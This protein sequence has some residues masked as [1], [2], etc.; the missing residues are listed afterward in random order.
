MPIRL[1]AMIV[2]K[3]SSGCGP[4]DAQSALGGRGAPDGLLDLSLL[5]YVTG[6]E[7]RLELFAQ[8]LALIGV[9][10]GD[11]DGRA[12]RRKRAHG[13]LAE[14]RS[15]A[16]G[17]RCR[18]LDVHRAGSLQVAAPRQREREQALRIGH[19]MRDLQARRG[20]VALEPLRREL[21]GDLRA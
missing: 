16:H 20:E 8:R 13:R 1:I 21:G 9:D 6:D 4:R 2:S 12:A 14:A 15:P 10:V 3:G 11:R 5:A 17:D 7:V 19:P 18:A